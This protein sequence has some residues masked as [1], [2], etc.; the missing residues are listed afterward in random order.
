MSSFDRFMSD[1][2]EEGIN[3]NF[4]NL[5]LHDQGYANNV[6]LRWLSKSLNVSY[7]RQCLDAGQR[8]G[9]LK[10]FECYTNWMT[11]TL[12][13][14]PL[15]R[16]NAGICLPHCNNSYPVGFSVKSIYCTG[17]KNELET[18]CLNETKSPIL[19][20]RFD[21]LF[22]TKYQHSFMRRIFSLN[23]TVSDRSPMYKNA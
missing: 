11:N 13:L 15:L 22:H 7:D 18:S 21:F 5:F 10:G 3:G 2:W 16:G 9:N 8:G 12:H 19:C 6:A 4:H 14:N 20:R 23:E 1:W 17:H